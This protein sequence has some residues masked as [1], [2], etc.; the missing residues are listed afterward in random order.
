MTS[1]TA[2]L[3]TGTSSGIGQATAARLARRKDLTVYA[4]ARRHETLSDLAAAGAHPLALDVTDE[5]SMTAAVQAI[6]ERHQHVGIL[7]NNAGYG[8]Y[9]TIEETALNDVRR[10]FETNVF[11]LAR[12]TQLVLPA[13]RTARQGRIINVGSMGGRLV[14]PVGGYYHA[15]KYA[16]EALTDALRFETAS[17]GVKVSLIEPGLIRT[18]FG[19]VAA[20]TQETSADPS[21]PYGALS[22]ANENQM[23]TSYDSAM[24]SASPESVAKVIERAVTARRPR[25]RYVVT[26]AAKT[27]VHTR[28]ILGGRAFDAYLKLQYRR[29]A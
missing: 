4:T 21:G 29:V 5:D 27:L 15:S 24:L 25:T 8:A 22:A 3:I 10:Q 13:M 16:V 1:T 2:V 18:G 6:E 12:M 7:I 20:R 14:F 23:R 26:P 11:G 28:R 17:F 9:G 19:D